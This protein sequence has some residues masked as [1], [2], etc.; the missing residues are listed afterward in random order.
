MSDRLVWKEDPSGVYTVKS[1]YRLVERKSRTPGAGKSGCSTMDRGLWIK[2]WGLP[3]QPKLKFFVWELLHRILPTMEALLEKKVLVLAR[4][5]DCWAREE[6]TEHLFPECPVARGLW[7]AAELVAELESLPTGCFEIFFRRFLQR[8]ASVSRV[9]RLVCLLWRIWKGRNSV[10]FEGLQIL[11]SILRQEFLFQVHEWLQVPQDVR[12]DGDGHARM[13]SMVLPVGQGDSVGGIICSFDGAVREGSHAA[14]GMVLRDAAGM[15]LVDKGV[16]YNGLLNPMLTELSTLRDAIRWCR[17]LGF[18]TMRIEGDAKVVID[19]VNTRSIADA[20]G[21]AI[22]EEIRH[23]LSAL[24][25]FQI[26]F[27]GRQNNRVA[28]LVAKKALS[29]FPTGCNGF[30]FCA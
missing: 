6:T 26:R 28:H 7:E 2:V 25:G 19:K 5:P 8:D 10:A 11:P 16:M 30:D 17:Q 3:I 13:S 14:G 4:C 20:A 12:R 21:G 23:L 15:V 24:P 22:F 27:V 29:L 9:V 1:G 18:V